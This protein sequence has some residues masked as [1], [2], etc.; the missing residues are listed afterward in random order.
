MGMAMKDL[1]R[2]VGLPTDDKAL[3]EK[4]VPEEN[5]API[6]ETVK[7]RSSQLRAGLPRSPQ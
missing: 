1:R 6:A 4:A 5:P 2:Q 7:Q 3:L